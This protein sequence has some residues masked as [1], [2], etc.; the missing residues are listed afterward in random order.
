MEAADLQSFLKAPVESWKLPVLEVGRA[1]LVYSDNSARCVC[2]SGVL[3]ETKKRNGIAVD[4]CPECRA[5]WLD[6]GELA[7]LLDRYREEPEK[8]RYSFLQFVLDF[9]PFPDLF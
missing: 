8:R 9:L 1:D 2:S 4:V 5:V 3:M 6:G 7:Q